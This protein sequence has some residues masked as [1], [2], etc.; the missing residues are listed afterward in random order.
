MEIQLYMWYGA[1][2]AFL[3]RHDFYL[4]QAKRRLIGQ[5]ND[6]EGEATQFADDQFHRFGSWSGSEDTDL[7]SLAEQATEDGQ[8]HYDQL[9][10]LRANVILS[11]LAGLYHQ[12]E[13]ELRS[14]IEHE[15]K[16]DITEDS[17]AAIWKGPIADIFDLLSQ[18]GWKVA[19]EQF[20]DKLDASRLVVNA[21][22]HGKGSAMTQ[23]YEKHPEY[24]RGT[25]PRVHDMLPK[26]VIDLRYME[27]DWLALTEEQM[28]ELAAAIRQFWEAFP[29]RLLYRP[30]PHTS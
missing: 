13:K 9:L 30:P 24:L 19:N 20:F 12:W 6:I 17:I 5:F 21:Y 29:E 4:D 18:F 15:L 16:R 23:L 22:K 25:Y 2:E 10:T 8:E 26:E 28:D 3:R 11:T 14:F 27:H 7:G 1:R